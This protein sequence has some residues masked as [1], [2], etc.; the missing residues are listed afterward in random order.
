MTLLRLNDPSPSVRVAHSWSAFTLI[1][2][3]VVM[4]VIAIMVAVSLTPLRQALSQRQLHAQAKAEMALIAEALESYRAYYGDYPWIDDDPEALYRALQGYRDG[5]DT[6]GSHHS[7]IDAAQF[8]L[9]APFEEGPAGANALL[10]PWGT[11]YY[12]SYGNERLPVESVAYGFILI[13]AGPDGRRGPISVNVDG[14]MAADY[15]RAPN[16]SDDL[17]KGTWNVD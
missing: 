5:V 16:G 3:L 7:F 17:V 14:T 6:G 13:S 1:E 12:Y 9:R 8:T 2:L 11:P 10:D 4:T 15:S